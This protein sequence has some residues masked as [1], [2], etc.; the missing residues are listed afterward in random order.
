ME[1]K[2]LV[3]ISGKSGLFRIIKPSRASIIVETLDPQKKKLVV[4]ANQRISVLE[5]ISIYTNTIDGST[6]LSNVLKT[7]YREFGSEPA[8]DD[9]ASNAEYQS[10][11]KSVLPEYDQERV[12]VSDIKKI[13]RWYHVLLREAPHLV[14]VQELDEGQEEE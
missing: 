2:D 7:I 1:L 4:S 11:F 5:E 10:F 9:E 8:L 13:V 14:G 6:P 12:Y 3:S